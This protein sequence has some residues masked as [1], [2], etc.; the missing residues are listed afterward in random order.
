MVYIFV[1]LS[2]RMKSAYCGNISK[3]NLSGLIAIV[4]IINSFYR[5]KQNYLYRR[6]AGTFSN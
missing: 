5:R 6:L 1:A 2:Q 3:I 4:S